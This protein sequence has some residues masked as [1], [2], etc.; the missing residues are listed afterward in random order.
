MIREHVVPRTTSPIAGSTSAGSPSDWRGTHQ[1]PSSKSSPTRPASSSASRVFPTPPGS[2]DRDGAMLA[3]QPPSSSTHSRP[4]RRVAGGGRSSK[5]RPRSAGNS[6]APTWSDAAR[7]GR[8]LRRCSPRSLSKR[9]Q[10]RVARVSSPKS[11]SPAVGG[12]TDPP[13]QCTS[14]PTISLFR[15][16]RLA[17]WIPFG[18][19]CGLPRSA[20]WS[21]SDAAT[22]SSGLEN[23]MKN[24]S[25]CVSTSK[26]S[27]LANEARSRRRCS[28]SSPIT[29]AELRRRR[30]DPSMSVKRNVTVP[31]G[32]THHRTPPTA[33]SGCDWQRLR[34]ARAE[35][36]ETSEAARRVCARTVATSRRLALLPRFDCA[37]PPRRRCHPA[38]SAA[39]EQ[40]QQVGDVFPVTHAPG[41]ARAFAR[42]PPRRRRCRPVPVARRAFRRPAT[43]ATRA[44]PLRGLGDLLEQLDGTV[45]DHPRRTPGCRR[46][47]RPGAHAR[48]LDVF[49]QATRLAEQRLRLRD[50]HLAGRECNPH[51]RRRGAAVVSRGTKGS[52]RLLVERAPRAPAQHPALFP[53]V[54]RSRARSSVGAAPRRSRRPRRARAPRGV[55]PA[56]T[57][58]FSSANRIR[59]SSS[60]SSRS[61]AQSSAARMFS[62]SEVTTS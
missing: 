51:K 9:R 55:G 59:T 20:R 10:P 11:A 17:C 35:S 30:V 57:H 52:E 47:A 27:C 43:P 1:T 23:A 8:S 15:H 12:R 39:R 14:M 37:E 40:R 7:Q 61:C 3:Q 21:S 41:S 44:E 18:H 62:A 25:P 56:V 49:E 34:P 31:R 19:V 28:P 2:S 54:R 13:P 24:A 29:V 50:V 45:D 6:S 36:S 26:P 60:V 48:K 53:S 4:T 46:A 38:N 22:A 58:Q 42:T 5:C 33:S 32:S 16:E